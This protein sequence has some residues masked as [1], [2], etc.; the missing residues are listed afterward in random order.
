MPWIGMTF[1]IDANSILHIPAKDKAP[2]KAL[3]HF[4]A[5]P[6]SEFLQDTQRCSRMNM[7]AGPGM[8]K[9]YGA[10]NRTCTSNPLPD[11]SLRVYV[12]S[13]LAGGLS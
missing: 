6:V 8:A 5:G 3:Y 11:I 7:P 12:W 2:G 9:V 10:T 13:L 1:D 4:R